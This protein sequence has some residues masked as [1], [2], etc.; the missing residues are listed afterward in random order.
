MSEQKKHQAVNDALQFP[1]AAEFEK[2]IID[3][4]AA[5]EE[6]SEPLVIAIIDLD[7]F[8]HINTDFGIEAGDRML[9]DTG[10]FLAEGLPEGA[11]IYRVAG[12]EFGIVFK[13]M[14]KEEVF[15]L[16]EKKRA[17]FSIKA[18]NGDAQTISI[19][20]AAAFDD[21]QRY[22]ELLRKAESAMYRAK[23]SGHNRVALA[24]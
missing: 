11:A 12:D 13:G 24:R 23:Y 10:R 4:M 2:A 16:M 14:E 5:G 6:G 19:G 1:L 21:A 8:M 3:F 18:P 15:L 9:I 7:S 20:I 22:Q 17:A